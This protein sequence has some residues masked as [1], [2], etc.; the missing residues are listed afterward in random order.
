MTCGEAVFNTTCLG[1][2]TQPSSPVMTGPY[3]PKKAV[4]TGLGPGGLKISKPNYPVLGQCIPGSS[5]GGKAQSFSSFLQSGP[6]Y[7]QNNTKSLL[8]GSGGSC[9]HSSGSVAGGGAIELVAEKGEITINAAIIASAQTAKS[10]TVCS[11]GSGGLIRLK[12][13]KVHIQEKGKLSVEG[14]NGQPKNNVEAILGGGAGG[15]IQII[16]SEG[17]LAAYTSSTETR[18]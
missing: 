10:S 4:Y 17:S 13:Q 18:L 6:S 2:F 1:G 8:G 11:G 12:S 14:G 7:D 5:H 16:A 15:I 3:L 9:L